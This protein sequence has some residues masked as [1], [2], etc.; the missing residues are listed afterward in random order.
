MAVL[1]ANVKAQMMGVGRLTVPKNANPW[2]IFNWLP[3]KYQTAHNIDLTKLQNYTA[4]ELLEL[5]VSVH[6]DVSHALHTYLRMGE[7][8]LSFTADN[9][10]AQA[11]LDVLVDM[12]S[13]PLPSPGYQH[14]RSLDKLDG[15]QR[16]MVMVR[17]A[18][19]GEV[20]LNDQ[21]NDVVDIVPVDPMLIWFRRH[22]DTQRLE[23]WQFVR[24][25]RMRPGEEW[26]GQYKKI[27]TPTFIYEELDPFVDDPYGRSPILPVLQVVFFHIQ[28][29][30]DIK[31]VVHNQGYRRMDVKI[32][33]PIILKNMP[34]Q[35]KSDPN[36]QRTWLAGKYKEYQTAFQNLN[37]DDAFIH[38]DSVEIG[39]MQGGPA[40]PMIDVT[41][42]INVIDTQLA[43]SLK[44]LLTLLSRHQGSTETYSSI[45]TQIY[46]KTVE[47]ARSVTK[48][49]WSRAFALAARVRGVQTAVDADYAPIDLRTENEQQADITARIE[50]LESA[51][52]NYYV[53]PEEAAREAR[54]A[55]GLDP[56]I[57]DELVDK[58]G[59]K[60]ETPATPF[61]D[62]VETTTPTPP[63]PTPPEPA[64]EDPTE[65][66]A[67]DPGT[68]LEEPNPSANRRVQ[69]GTQPAPQQPT[70]KQAEEQFLAWYLSFMRHVRDQAK[71]AITLA[72]LKT[73]LYM[74]S[75]IS[76]QLRRGLYQL[77]RDS[78]VASYNQ[79]AVKIGTQ[80]I[81][82]PDPQT[83]IELSMQA[84][85]VI[86]GINQ[87][88]DHEMESAFQEA[89]A[90]TENLSA[91]EQLAKVKNI[92]DQ[93]ANE[94]MDYKS[95]QITQHEAIDTYHQGMFAHDTV[96]A[97]QT[98][99]GV[100]PSDSDH[101]ACIVVIEGAPY[102]LSQAR[103][104]PLPLHPNCPHHYVPLD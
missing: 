69:L 102:T 14:G 8:K 35:F 64:Q 70:Q 75:G 83:S 21:V 38:W 55:M 1:P 37:P 44:T 92:M 36:A 59:A 15:V 19:A 3:K 98:M 10:G 86:S 47:S 94:R 9:D 45:D 89:V 34:A 104:T 85:S 17:G 23:P 68:E 49:F 74:N 4:E 12:F 60:H 97:P 88:Y 5:L 100:A 39:Y 87:T 22:P 31:A 18:C 80:T 101:E 84:S 81:R 91:E 2:N 67:Q 25:P 52:S 66:P 7:T 53:T 33:E 27:D 58:L 90:T 6:P 61:Q 28:V 26:F 41:K 72:S 82:F 56:A 63:E 32:L 50:N 46:I 20:V 76:E 79:R 42:L 95:T 40:G 57:P 11:V 71:H 62:D 103:S 77:Y 30:Q 29:L 93:W 48:R 13:K 16:L 54:I 96:H 78:Y 99:Y 73:A 43:T 24:F 51:E 65:D